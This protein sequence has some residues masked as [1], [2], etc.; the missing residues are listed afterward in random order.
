MSTASLLLLAYIFNGIHFVP[1]KLKINL[2]KTPAHWTLMICSNSWFVTGAL[3]K[4]GFTEDI[5]RSVTKEKNSDFN[6]IKFVSV[7]RC[8]VYVPC[9]CSMADMRPKG[10]R[11]PLGHL[12]FGE[13]HHWYLCHLFLQWSLLSS[14]SYNQAIVPGPRF[15]FLSS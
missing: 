10:H 6:K 1:K 3:C 2:I 12:R 9:Q 8:H 14:L 5:V 4:N 7:Q 11:F 15:R 13:L